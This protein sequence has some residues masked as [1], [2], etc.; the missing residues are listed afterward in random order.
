MGCRESSAVAEQLG[1]GAASRRG[2]RKYQGKHFQKMNKPFGEDSILEESMLNVGALMTCR[3]CPVYSFELEIRGKEHWNLLDFTPFKI[4][5]G[6]FFG[7]GVLFVC[8]SLIFNEKMPWQ[9]ELKAIW[10][11]SC[12]QSQL[13]PQ[14]EARDFQKKSGADA[15]ADAKQI[16]SQRVHLVNSCCD[17]TFQH[18][19]F[20]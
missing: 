13:S 20:T 2:K 9:G 7:S 3:E 12:P 4:T 8:V 15:E 14:A 10:G 6:A 1:K 16:W 19:S 17:P 11:D 5:S 18:H